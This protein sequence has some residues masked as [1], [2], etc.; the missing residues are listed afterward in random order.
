MIRKNIR[1]NENKDKYIEN[2]LYKALGINFDEYGTKIPELFEKNPDP[3][4]YDNYI[5]NQE[6]VA[7]FKRQMG[8]LENIPYAYYLF[9]AAQ[10]S[11]PVTEIKKIENYNEETKK[12]A[13]G[14]NYD[15][16]KFFIFNIVQS[17]LYKEKIDRED[18]KNK[19]MKIIDSNDETEVEKF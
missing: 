19:K 18:E 8:W 2:T 17:L 16:D 4:I 13:F 6:I 14:I 7:N 3:K 15:F 11:D 1:K 9:E 12:E 10:K 5:I